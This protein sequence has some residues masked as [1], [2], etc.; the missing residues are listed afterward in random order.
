M[1]QKSEEKTGDH[2]RLQQEF[3]GCDHAFRYLFFSSQ[4]QFPMCISSLSLKV[5]LARASVKDGAALDLFSECSVSPFSKARAARLP[6]HRP[7]VCLPSLLCGAGAEG[8]AARPLRRGD[9]RLTDR[10]GESGLFPLC[11]H[12][13]GAGPSQAGHSGV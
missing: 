5:S 13:P 4:G 7:W 9:S 2:V 12:F 1:T 11:P 10:L 8:R 3:L 6:P